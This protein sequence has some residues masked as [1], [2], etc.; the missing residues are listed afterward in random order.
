MPDKK[1]IMKEITQRNKNLGE[2]IKTIRVKSTIST[3]EMASHLNI[4]ENH[5]IEYEH[6]DTSIYADHLISISKIFNININVLLN[7]YL[8][9]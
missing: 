1:I 7:V 8:K 9:N 6:G 3:H 4:T 2:Y 5:Y